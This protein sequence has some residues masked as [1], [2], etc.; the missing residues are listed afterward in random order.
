MKAIV[1][2]E[3]GLPDDVLELQDMDKPII[4]DD[5]ALVLKDCKDRFAV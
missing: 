1:H 2:Y 4:K 5:E 3:Y